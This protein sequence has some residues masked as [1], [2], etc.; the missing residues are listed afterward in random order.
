MIPVTSGVQPEVYEATRR[1]FV[2]KENKNN[3]F[4]QQFLLLCVTYLKHASIIYCEWY[5]I[6][7]VHVA[8]WLE[9]CVSSTKVVG[10]IPSEQIMFTDKN[11]YNL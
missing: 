3:D 1:R 9:H 10:S 6:Y 7:S 4:I 2:H 8:Q 5:S 11:M